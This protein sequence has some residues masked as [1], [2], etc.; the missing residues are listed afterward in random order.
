MVIGSLV[1]KTEGNRVFCFRCDFIVFR[2]LFHDF[3]GIVTWFTDTCV[4][5]T[6]SKTVNKSVF[7][8]GLRKLPESGFQKIT[9]LTEEN[10]A[11][12]K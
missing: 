1:I 5:E 9:G 12:G 7:P 11:P 6:G 10:D 2:K 3:F 4:N 8:V